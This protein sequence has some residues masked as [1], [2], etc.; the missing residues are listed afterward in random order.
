MLKKEETIMRYSNS[1]MIPNSKDNWEV[2]YVSTEFG[3]NFKK[4]YNRKRQKKDNPKAIWYFNSC[5]EE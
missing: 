3:N 1:V 5:M 2:F 4:Y